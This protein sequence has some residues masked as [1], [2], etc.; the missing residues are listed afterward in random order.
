MKLPVLIPLVL[1]QS[2]FLIAAQILL[3]KSVLL[4]GKFTWSIEYFRNALTTW[5]FAAS[6]ILAFAAWI[7]WMYIL[8]HNDFSLAYSLLF[9]GYIIGMFAAQFLLHEVIPL[10][11][12]IGI[13]LAIVGA[14][15]I[16][17]K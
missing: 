13:I 16:V 14:I 1:L 15:L 12:W 9:F 3:K 2:I 8:K 4:F 6:G 17:L 11:R 10:T 7:V 5:Q